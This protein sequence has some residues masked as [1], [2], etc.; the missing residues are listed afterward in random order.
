MGLRTCA[1]LLAG[2]ACTAP[3]AEPMLAPA[4]P[5]STDADAVA[6][7]IDPDLR[8]L[9][10]DHWTWHRQT[11]P[12]EA[13]TYGDHRH[14]TRL[15]DNSPAALADQGRA[16]RRFLTRA[17]A[18]DGRRLQPEDRRTWQLLQQRLAAQIAREVCQ[19]EQ[20][21]VSAR[22]D[23]PIKVFNELP[24]KHPITS[25]ADAENLLARYRAVAVRVDNIVAH[26]R[27]GL[28]NNR[29]ANAES[30][31]RTL[32]LVQGQL[33]QP[34]KRWALF[35]PAQVTHL[36]WTPKQQRRFRHAVLQVLENEILPAYQRYYDALQSEILPFARGEDQPGLVGLPQGHACY[37][38][39]IQHYL[40]LERTPQEL[41]AL[42]LDEVE[43]INQQMR[44]LGRTLF[45]TDDLAEIFDRLRTD[46]ALYFETAEDMLATAR[47]QLKAATAK[48]PQFFDV[49]PET[50]CV[51]LPVPRYEAPFTTIAYYESPHADGSKPGEYF[52]NTY[53]PHTRPR[54]ELA[55]LT[56][57]ESN[58]GH[59]LQLALSQE[60][61]AL[62][63][64]RRFFSVTA[65]V[66]GWAL[67]TERLADEM[68]L[69]E[70]DLERMG[71]LSYD[72][73]RASR[74]V[75][76]TGLHALGWT[77]NQAEAFLHT[78]TA[79]TPANITNEVDRYITTPGQALAYKV[80][81]LEILKWR[82]Q[83]EKRLGTA[84]DIRQFHQTVLEQGAVSLPVLGQQIERWIQ[85]RETARSQVKTHS[86]SAHRG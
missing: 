51:V 48:L 85:A 83:A 50:P 2:T 39:Q 70:S 33:K 86:S 15:F 56:F 52:V 8:Q 45:E 77:R 47:R 14:D 53:L 80:G 29:V 75:V 67:Y 21:S 32:A 54:F 57:H 69:Y 3:T 71:M 1:L 9:L 41:H 43:R 28:G 49:V 62:P 6:G 12:V 37:Q 30:I 16:R 17:H 63:A 81:Q 66:E 58:P 4:P 10:T 34:L 38:A 79:L 76:D 46:R 78:H 11:Y 84:F 42:G 20:W 55:A 23:N 44:Q 27:R 61:L 13:T 65:F 7:V 24:K 74:L 72:A 68:G 25:Y 18:L 22:V 82:A 40:Q 60:R 36:S 35:A 5:S 31:R 64:F 73:W 26:L 19:M 59:H